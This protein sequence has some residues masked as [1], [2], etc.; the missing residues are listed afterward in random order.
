MAEEVSL[1]FRLR[2]IDETRNYLL[3]KIK[4]N[5][6]MIEKYKKT[7]KYLHY[8]ELLVI[9]S[10]TVTSCVSVSA[11]ALLVCV[12]VGVTSS[13]VRIKI[14]A[15][16]KGIKKYKSIITKKKKHDKIVLLG[17]DKLNAILISNK[18]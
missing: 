4:H 15:I 11:F 9:L 6:L 12:P 10:S 13:A 7:C 1:E 3:D 17:K 18:F 14:C 16:A 2:K 8:V 5:Y